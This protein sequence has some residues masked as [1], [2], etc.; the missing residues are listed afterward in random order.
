MAPPS[1]KFKFCE[2]SSQLPQ[3]VSLRWWSALI[4]L[5]ELGLYHADEFQPCIEAELRR[6]I[7]LVL[8]AP[9]SAYNWIELVTTTP[10]PWHTSEDVPINYLIQLFI[11]VSVN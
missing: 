2:T 6:D 8:N 10:F 5:P 7:A 11:L 1:R 9:H 4:S 3:T